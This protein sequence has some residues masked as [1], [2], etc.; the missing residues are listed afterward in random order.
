MELILPSYHGQINQ[1][2]G[3]CCLQVPINRLHVHYTGLHGLTWI[4]HS[5]TDT[6]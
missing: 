1:F 2:W 3:F 4:L 5:D 6:N